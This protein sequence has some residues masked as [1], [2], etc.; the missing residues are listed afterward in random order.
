MEPFVALSGSSLRVLFSSGLSV[1]FVIFH[2]LG[3]FSQGF[4]LGFCCSGL[5]IFGS[6]S[7]DF[8]MDYV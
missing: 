6:Y 1:E 3:T 2:D 5:S 4:L 8:G 7:L